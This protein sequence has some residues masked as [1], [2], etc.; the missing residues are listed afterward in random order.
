MALE[1]LRICVYAYAYVCL[2]VR[3]PGYE[4][5]YLCI[6]ELLP[7][8]RVCIY[9]RNCVLVYV[10]LRAFLSLLFGPK[11]SETP[12]P[13][14]WRNVG[15]IHTEILSATSGNYSLLVNE[16]GSLTTLCCHVT[17][18]MVIFFVI[19]WKFKKRQR[20]KRF[21]KRLAFVKRWWKF[22]YPLF[23]GFK[24]YRYV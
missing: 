7:C 4:N 6:S 8:V 10:Y 20:I 5:L 22:V 17:W 2:C 3:L 1:S 9:E 24:N 19:S 16:A 12:L 21:S 14:G 23:W 11:K 15:V 13:N 18:V